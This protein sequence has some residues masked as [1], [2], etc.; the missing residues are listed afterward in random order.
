MTTRSE[1]HQLVDELPEDQVDPVA[2]AMITAF[3]APVDDEA[4]DDDDRAAIMDSGTEYL[5]A[6]DAPIA[7]VAAQL[8]ELLGY[9]TLGVIAG[10]TE[11]Q[12]IR[13]W[14]DGETRPPKLT[15]E[16]LRFT[17]RA[18][19]IIRHRFPV[20]TVSVFFSGMNHRLGDRSPAIVIR[21]DY[22]EET[23]HAILNAAS[24]FMTTA[25]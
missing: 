24:T 21:E 8:V 23:R 11:A 15:D 10:V 19:L 5:V 18:T 12:T 25:G 2:R 13:L 17:L 1:L 16:K 7:D 20:S 4:I 22:R 14:T 3:L 9:P 6:D